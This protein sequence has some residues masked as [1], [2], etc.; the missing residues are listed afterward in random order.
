MDT[1][2]WG[3]GSRVFF[4]TEVRYPV[5]HGICQ[6]CKLKMFQDD[7]HL[8]SSKMG[9]WESKERG[10]GERGREGEGRREEEKNGGKER[11]KWLVVGG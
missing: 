10:K 7:Q 6:R 4:K 5:P 3:P 2:N 1:R 9:R 8:L 11:R